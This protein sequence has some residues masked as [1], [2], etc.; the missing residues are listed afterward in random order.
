M[1]K[2]DVI[3]NDGTVQQDEMYA[4][5]MADGEIIGMAIDCDNGKIWYSKDGYWNND[6]TQDGVIGGR[7][8]TTLNAS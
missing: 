8:S 5:N 7:Q 6:E 4:G 3:K 1:Y 2:N